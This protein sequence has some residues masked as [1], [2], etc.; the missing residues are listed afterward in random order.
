MLRLCHDGGGNSPEQAIFLDS[1]VPLLA[2]AG[3]SLA[4]TLSGDSPWR[5]RL[6]GSGLAMRSLAASLTSLVISV[7][8]A[9]SIEPEDFKARS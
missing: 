6:F 9:Y 8:T 1:C 5:G 7:D 2:D 3:I 4:L